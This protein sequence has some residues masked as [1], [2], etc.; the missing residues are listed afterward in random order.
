MPAIN[1]SSN[2]PLVV[3]KVREG[4]RMA[5]AGMDRYERKG[6]PSDKE[7]LLRV[8]SEVSVFVEEMEARLGLFPDSDPDD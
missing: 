4:L 1:A 7:V 6:N 5:R 2:E 8:Y 3:E